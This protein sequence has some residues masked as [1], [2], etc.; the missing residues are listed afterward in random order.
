MF[1][2]SDQVGQFQA[3]R[4]AAPP[5]RDQLQLIPEA[6]QLLQEG[7]REAGIAGELGLARSPGRQGIAGRQGAQA[8]ARHRL[9]GAQA[10][11]QQPQVMALQGRQQ[12]GLQF[13]QLARFDHGTAMGLSRKPQE[14]PSSRR[15]CTR[16]IR[17]SGKVW[18]IK[19]SSWSQTTGKASAIRITEQ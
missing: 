4:I 13:R 19:A 17:Q 10:M 8:A 16:S 9:E 6:G 11:G 1:S 3:Q 18:L 12:G 2:P 14:C 15:Q 7:G 5:G